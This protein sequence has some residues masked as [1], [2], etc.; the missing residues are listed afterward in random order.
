[1]DKDIKYHWR[2]ILKK[3]QES[4]TTPLSIEHHFEKSHIMPAHEQID[5]KVMISKQKAKGEFIIEPDLD[6]KTLVSIDAGSTCI[7]LKK[8]VFEREIGRYLL[9]KEGY[10]MR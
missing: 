2:N 5:F 8:E 9:R 1:M 10:L 3:F 7:K 4:E 6:N